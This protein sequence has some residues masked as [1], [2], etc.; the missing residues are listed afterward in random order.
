MTR[1]ISMALSSIFCACSCL[2]R[3]FASIALTIP[4]ERR[5]AMNS[6]LVIMPLISPFFTTSSIVMLSMVNK[7]W[8]LDMGVSSMT[9]KGELFLT[10]RGSSKSIGEFQNWSTTS[11]WVSLISTKSS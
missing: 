3:S 5:F 9:R 1:A 7:K 11:L 10:I 8:I 4:L 2:F 6:N